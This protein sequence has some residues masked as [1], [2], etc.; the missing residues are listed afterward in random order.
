M[1]TH[2]TDRCVHVRSLRVAVLALA[3]L[4]VML[5]PARSRAASPTFFQGFEV[6]TSGWF[7]GDG[8][9]NREADGYVSPVPYASGITSSA[10]TH[11]ARL[12]R[13][14]CDTEIAGGG[15]TVFCQG[16]FTRWG[17]YNKDWTGGY[18]TQVDVYFDVAYAIAHPDS[19]GG[20]IAC[21]TADPS[22][23]SCPGT[24]FDFSSAINDSTGNFLSDFVFNVGTGPDGPPT[25]PGGQ[26]FV[27]TASTNAFRSG[28]NPYNPGKDPFCISTS[29][30]YTLRHTFKDVGG[31]LVVDMD[32]MQGNAIVH[33]WSITTTN[34]IAS[35]GCNRYGWFA[36]EEIWDLAI[37]NSQMTGCGVE[38][39][40][41]SLDGW[42]LVNFDA[43]TSA[44][45]GDATTTSGTDA[46]FVSG[47]GAPPL[48]TGSMQ[49]VIGTNGDD[50]TRLRTGNCNGTLLTDVISLPLTYWTYVTTNMGAQATY[51]QLRVDQ[52]G[53]GTTDDRLF[54]E[55]AYQNGGYG[56]ITGPP[57]PDQCPLDP[58]N[59]VVL[60]TWQFWDA[61]IG[62]WWSDNESAGGPPLITLADYAAE[63][64]GVKVAT[65]N[66][67]L[68]VQAGGG[69]GAWDN[70]NGATDDLTACG[71]T[72]NFEQGV[73]PTATPAA[74]PGPTA[75][76]TAPIPSPTSTP[77]PLDHVQCY[78]MPREPFTRLSGVSL[79][80]H[81]GPSTVD[82]IRPKR[83]CN[84]ADKN[85]E[86]P[87]APNDP[88]HL[89]GYI[90]KQRTPFPR[91]SGVS[92]T[93]QF[94]TVTMDLRRADY[95][96][97][98]TAKSLSV[99]PPPLTPPT[100]DHFKC[101]KVARAKARI[102]GIKVDDEFGTVVEDIK[103]PMRLCIPADKNGE[104][105]P[106]PTSDSLLCYKMRQTSQPFFRGV[107]PIFI[108]NQFG[109][110]T[111]SVDHLRELCVP[112]S[113][114]Y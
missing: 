36:N 25:C 68:R 59:C 17:G 43:T 93:N 49:Q 69:A 63:H 45:V 11:H 12:R 51:L 53:D 78:Q 95:L 7:P 52:D 44:D 90:I 110:S 35:V 101:Y 64:P 61:R 46:N 4:F 20:N 97:V 41:C 24:R 55:P 113:V 87:N 74:T 104:G 66:P 5:A 29:G 23:T 54:F 3:T 75:T 30:W 10:G 58:V 15:P 80:D 56:M 48:G 42:E 96:L 57:V 109:A 99:A 105:I 8:T 65:D 100:I 21:L 79:A 32:L 31:F 9:A 47:P 108:N 37:D 84:P 33:H 34:A 14:T 83:L 88:D 70:F 13:A 6:D 27:M 22:D 18:T 98:P 1:P 91:A 26:G 111:I 50:A 81:F 2:F 62:G 106:D 28:A 77:V 82:V 107:D 76:M 73:C 94:G 72:Y 114:V 102:A 38:V 67:S 16:A 92:V 39:T 86:N 85:D 103:R 19:Y 60:N 40:Q 71:T 89:T 112:S